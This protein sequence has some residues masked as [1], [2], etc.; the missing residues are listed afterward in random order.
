MHLI[1]KAHRYSAAANLAD[2][3]TI[4]DFGTRL[5]SP[6]FQV[7]I[8]EDKKVV[9]L[10]F[11]EQQNEITALSFH[12]GSMKLLWEKTFMPEN[13][14]FYRDFSQMIVDNNGNMH[15]ILEKDNQKSKQKDHYLEVFQYGD[16]TG[17]ELRRYVINMQGRLTYD[18][19]FAFDHLNKRLIAGGLYSENS[20]SRADG[21]FY[22]NVLP[23]SGENA[24]LKF[25][26]FE[27]DFVAVLLEKDK[28]KNKGVPEVSIQEIVL[29]RDGGIILIGELNKLYQ[30]GVGTAGMYSR[31]GFRSIID[32]YYDDIFLIS[33][34]PDGVVHWK[35]ILH[36][37]Q[38]SQDDNAAYS[39][40]FLMK[41]A[42]A[43]RLIFNDEIKVEN[44]VSEYVIKG[45]G[46][47]D[48]N[49][50]MNTERKDL[51]LRFRDAVQ[52]SANELIVPSER[53][54]KL[55]LVKVAF[56]DNR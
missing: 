22:L 53:R 16:A 43:L 41:T 37:K 50:V 42:T 7:A 47:L 51:Q 5:S 2:S 13:L 49:A 33:L 36:K 39:S 56:N 35:N 25:H 6:N 26:P 21:F 20:L 24:V 38:Y 15:F 30:R 11:V 46:E 48:R 4:K 14:E 10:W 29:R 23:Y 45:D 44:L 3:I 9:L 17:E 27:D 28:N 12:M 55:K 34:H 31:T 18:A 1:L 32:Y 54:S 40:Y 19:N 8:S 52:I